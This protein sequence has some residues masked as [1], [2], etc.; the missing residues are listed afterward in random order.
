MTT[1]FQD[2]GYDSDMIFAYKGDNAY[3][4]GTYLVLLRDNGTEMPLFTIEDGLTDSPVRNG[5]TG[6]P[7]AVH[8]SDVRPVNWP[9]QQAKATGGQGD[10]IDTDKEHMRSCLIVAMELLER[11]PKLNTRPDQEMLRET[12]NLL[13]PAQHFRDIDTG[14]A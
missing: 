11:M 4:K 1:Y 12:L 3:L 14:E 10:D 5:L 6:M 2:A 8:I 9:Y 13:D 7:F